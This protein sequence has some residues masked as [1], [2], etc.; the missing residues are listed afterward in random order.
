MTSLGGKLLRGT[1]NNSLGEGKTTLVGWRDNK[2]AGV[3]GP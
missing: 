1:E 2:N 3:G